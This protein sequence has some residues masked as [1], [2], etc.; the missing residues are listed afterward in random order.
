MAPRR[1]K[2]WNILAILSVVVA[3]ILAVMGL[4]QIDVEPVRSRD[5]LR[6]TSA[7]RAL[8]TDPAHVLSSGWTSLRGERLSGAETAVDQ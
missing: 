7:S 3:T 6:L 4:A 2:R 5:S 1:Q 8:T